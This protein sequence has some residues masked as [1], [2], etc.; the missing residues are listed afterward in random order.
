MLCV[1]NGCMQKFILNRIKGIHIWVNKYYMRMLIQVYKEIYVYRE[2]LVCEASFRY[3]YNENAKFSEHRWKMAEVTEMYSRVYEWSNSGEANFLTTV[4]HIHKHLFLI[5][6]VKL[7]CKGPMLLL[8]IH[9]KSN[10]DSSFIVSFRDNKWSLQCFYKV[11][12]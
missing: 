12:T 7:I 11:I 1:E 6:S 4:T 5:V 2:R 8:V 3:R 10:R 9:V